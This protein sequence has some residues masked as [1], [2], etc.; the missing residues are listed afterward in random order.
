VEV[1]GEQPPASDGAPELDGVLRAVTRTKIRHYRQ[2]YIN[3]PEPIAF[4]PVTVDAFMP[5]VVDTSYIR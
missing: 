5:V 2:M 3:R 1:R 4:M